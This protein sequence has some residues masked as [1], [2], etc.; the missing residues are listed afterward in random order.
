[1]P[2]LLPPY[3]RSLQVHTGMVE[4]LR[5]HSISFE[6]SR[7]ILAKWVAQTYLESDEWVAEWEDICAAEI[8][9]WNAR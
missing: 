3:H 4:S 5:S 2:D 8:E 6:E 1:M 7:K 9:R